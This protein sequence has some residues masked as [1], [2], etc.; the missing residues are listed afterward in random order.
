[1]Q[2]SRYQPLFELPEKKFVRTNVDIFPVSRE[3]EPYDGV[4]EGSLLTLLMKR[5]ETD[6]N[7]QLARL[8]ASAEILAQKR[9]NLLL[10]S[11]SGLQFRSGGD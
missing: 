7:R 4:R 2:E 1:M 11:F 8:L 10:N 5:F 3:T 6:L 9:K